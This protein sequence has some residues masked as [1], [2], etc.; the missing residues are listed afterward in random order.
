MRCR[1]EAPSLRCCYDRTQDTD[2]DTA[3]HN[4]ARGGHLDVVQYLLQQGADPSVVNQ[5]SKTAA[6]EAEEPQVVAALVRAAQQQQ[7]QAVADAA[8]QPAS[9]E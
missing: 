1:Y 6:A 8:P 4:A 7:A 2:G 9:A 3:L 5:Q